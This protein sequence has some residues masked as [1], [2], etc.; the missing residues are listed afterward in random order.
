MTPVAENGD[1]NGAVWWRQIFLL[2]VVA[3][4]VSL[5]AEGRVMPALVLDGAVAFAFMPIAQVW[6]TRI[7]WRAR[8][9][10]PVTTGELSDYLDGNQP[11]LWWWC[12]FGALAAVMPPRALGSAGLFVELS[13]LAPFAIGILRDRRWL[14]ARL[15]RSPQE[16][17]ID[18][19]ALRLVTWGAALMWFYGLAAWHRY[20]VLVF[21]WVG[22]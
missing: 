12:A 20:G 21:P 15:A 17:W 18:V 10:R 14:E 22:A 13:L 11:W 1:D 4:A 19:A 8:F 9:R 16:A 5:A 2:F 3:C 7:V 6:G